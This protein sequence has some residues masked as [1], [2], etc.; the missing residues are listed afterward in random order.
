MSQVIAY[1]GLGSNL[2]D[3]RRFI[4]DALKMLEQTQGVADVRATEPIETVPLGELDQPKY[5]NAVAEIRTSLS[6]EKL[7]IRLTEI[8]DALGRKRGDKWASRT[9]DL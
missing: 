6:A 1:I 3:R 8:E 2:G 4:S 7:H 5:L 9:I